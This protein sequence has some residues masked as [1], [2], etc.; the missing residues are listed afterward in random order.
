MVDIT[1]DYILF[2]WY[3]F[4]FASPKLVPLSDIDY[5]TASKPT[6]Q[7]GKER[8]WGGGFTVWFPY[9]S[10]RPNRDTIFHLKLKGQS[11]WIGFTVEDTQRLVAVLREKNLLK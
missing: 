1:D 7:N 5:I 8:I 2:R 6:L 3:S 4:P 10:H 11:Q 9:D